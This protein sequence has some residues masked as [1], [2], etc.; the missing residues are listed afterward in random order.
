ML[1]CHGVSEE[2][3]GQWSPVGVEKQGLAQREA[4]GEPWPWVRAQQGLSPG[5]RGRSWWE[6]A[7][8]H[9]NKKVDMEQWNALLVAG[10]ES[11]GL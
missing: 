11:W 1:S 10:A 5:S 3:P 4:L 2:K 6:H 7:L 8:Y 9:V